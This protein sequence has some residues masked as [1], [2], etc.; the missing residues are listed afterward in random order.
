MLRPL[1]ILAA[2][3]FLAQSAV[4][5]RKETPSEKFYDDH[6]LG[7]AMAEVM[8]MRYPQLSALR[9][10]IAQCDDALSQN[11]V[12]QHYCRAASMN[13]ELEFGSDSK[14]DDLL[15]VLDI[16]RTAVRA[17]DAANARDPS[18]A[19]DVERLVNIDFK[20]RD[21]VNARFSALR[22]PPK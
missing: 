17:K 9:Q 18:M 4:A 5:Q 20:L 14:L 21:V 15:S 8:S 2:A 12:L 22:G 6:L 1:L 3:I 16:V 11:E 19:K 7:G 13:Y 10:V